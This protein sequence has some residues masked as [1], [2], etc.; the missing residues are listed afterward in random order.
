MLKKQNQNNIIFQSWTEDSNLEAECDK[1][2]GG[3]NDVTTP[4]PD[5]GCASGPICDNCNIWVAIND[6]KY[7]CANNCDYG[8]VEAE[9]GNGGVICHCYQ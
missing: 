1:N 3:G 9:T 6:V 2:G 4:K 8:Y 5:T 7:C